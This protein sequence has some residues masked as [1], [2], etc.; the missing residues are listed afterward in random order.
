[1]KKILYI[2]ISL[3]VGLSVNAQIY[4]NFIDAGKF[5]YADRNYPL[6]IYFY[7]EA[8]RQMPSDSIYVIYAANK[9][10]RDAH[11]YSRDYVNAIKYGNATIQTLENIG[12][13][14][15]YYIMEDSL[16]VANIHSL[17]GDSIIASKITDEVFGK[18]LHDELTWRGKQQ[19]TN[20]GGIVASHI[21]NW[22]MAESMYEL[23]S[24]IMMNR[25][26]LC[27]ETITSLNLYGN[28][29]HHNG[30]YDEA[31][32]IYE[33]QLE[34]CE[35][36]YGKDSREY[37]WTQYCIANILAYM[38]RINDGAAIYKDVIAWYRDRILNDLQ[39]IPSTEREVYLDNMIE[40]LQNAIPFGIE[41]KYNQD[42]FTALAYEC[43]LLSKGL[44]LATEKS[45][46]TIIRENGTN[47]EIAALSNLYQLK[48]DLTDLLANPNSDPKDVLNAYAQIKTIDVSLAN[49]CAKYGNNT[50]F[51]SIGY[52]QVKNNLKDGEVLLDFADFKPKS[53]PRQY[54]CFEIRHN[55]EYPSVHY[56]CNGA[57][58]DSLLSL[59][60][61]KWGNLYIG[62]AG[63]DMASIVGNRLSDIINGVKTVYYVPSGIFHKLAIEA[64]PSGK[65]RLGDE[66]TFYRL[67]SARELTLDNDTSTLS[68]AQLY[69]GLTYGQ[70]IKPLPQSLQEVNDISSSLNKTMN[71]KTFTADNGTKE[72]FMQLS[73]NAPNILHLS[74]H[75]FY[76]SPADINLPSSL[77]GYN[78]AMSLSGL[79]MS[80]GSLT[81]RL[82][83]LTA[84]EVAQCNLSNTEIACLASCH[85]GQG[86]VTSEGIY[87]MQRAFK[88]AGAGCVIMNLWEA[89]DVATKYFMINFYSDLI[90]GSKDRHKAFQYARDEVRKKYPSPF[91]WAGFIMID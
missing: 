72:S 86:E 59:E 83:L 10:L 90:H 31:L 15:S 37:H 81:S 26:K 50:S 12:A 41:A 46:E 22:P 20:L 84:N 65:N 3:I 70:D 62:E 91:Y 57:E 51:A 89:S 2:F 11:M 71:P 40:L 54:V 56:I 77:Q 8:L 58:L 61:Q 55:Q 79:V 53:K 42:E 39:S 87:G 69:G 64:I 19:L 47:E 32:K 27:D 60:N 85:S 18:A 68:T 13:S 52:K 76:Y 21:N 38:G 28:S 23:S 67:S 9:R 5:A 34:S 44:L 63:E 33:K 74:T 43:L 35:N 75:G 30:K 88:K 29:L 73:C 4:N 82:G 16:F 80:G 7:E 45:T 25:F 49:A 6:A 17:K 1:M 78:D 48:S 66:Y 14:G 24:Q 36:L